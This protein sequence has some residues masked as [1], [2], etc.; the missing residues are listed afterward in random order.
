M[1]VN[2]ER[3]KHCADSQN[4]NLE[5]SK[6][7]WSV[8]LYG[9]ESW[10]VNNEIRNRIAAAETWFLSRM[11]RISWADKVTNEEVL[12]RAGT[13]KE[14]LHQA[15]RRQMAFLGDAY[16]KD[17]ERQ[18]LRGRNPTK[19]GSWSTENN[20]RTDPWQLGNNGNDKQDRFS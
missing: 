20:I 19:M 4:Q 1:E 5:D 6:N 16:R 10:I 12:R 15:R 7:V 17:L 13:H 14:L 11:L 2:H 8:M 18:A 9:C 3:Q